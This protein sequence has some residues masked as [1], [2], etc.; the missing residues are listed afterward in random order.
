VTPTGDLLVA[1]AQR[2]LLLLAADGT[3]RWTLREEG[4]LPFRFANGVALGRSGRVYFTDASWRW[5]PEDLMREALEHRPNGRLLVHDPASGE[6]RRLL[7]DLYFA[8][9]VAVSADESFVLVAETFAYRVTRLWLTGPRAGEREHFIQNLPGFPD[10]IRAD[11]RGGYWLALYGPRD[12][13]LD[14]LGPYPTGRRLLLCLPAWLLPAPRRFGFVLALDEQGRVVQ[15]L[16]DPAGAYA[17]IS[18][19]TRLGDWLY[20]GSLT[21][22]AV[23]R[24]RLDGTR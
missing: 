18:S 19:A 12:A 7:G 23:G 17:P 14:A 8:N 5:G 11:A 22:P 1:D 16:Q 10:G 24:V 2:G 21:E 4:G 15:S 20:L 3:E 6:T 13:L 9:G